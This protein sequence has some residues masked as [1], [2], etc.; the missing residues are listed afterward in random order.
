[1][2]EKK[3]E[4]KDLKVPRKEDPKLHEPSLDPHLPSHSYKVS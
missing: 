1:M 4:E 3:G 2:K